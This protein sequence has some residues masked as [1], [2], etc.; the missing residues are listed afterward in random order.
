MAFEGLDQLKPDRP[1]CELLATKI[2]Q[3]NKAH[4]ALTIGRSVSPPTVDRLLPHTTRLKDDLPKYA[5]AWKCS[6]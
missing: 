5:T 3:V 4:N 1:N 2:D 6:S